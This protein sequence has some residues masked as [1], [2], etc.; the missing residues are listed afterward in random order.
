MRAFTHSQ[1][2]K[3]TPQAELGQ[4][5]I[6]CANAFMGEKQGQRHGRCRVLVWEPLGFN[7]ML[8]ARL[9]VSCKNRKPGECAWWKSNHES[10]SGFQP[11]KCLKRLTVIWEV[12]SVMRFENPIGGYDLELNSFL[13]P[14][15]KRKINNSL[16]SYCLCSKLRVKP[17]CV[18]IYWPLLT[19]EVGLLV[20]I[21]A[22]YSCSS[23]QRL[24]THNKETFWKEI[25]YWKN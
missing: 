25:I 7:G 20:G 23:R 4:M 17:I 19:L 15:S 12:E 13:Y 3:T 24:F 10:I 8:S 2:C 16:V 1:V 9:T 21:I 22:I 5:I 14:L 11:T 6:S 18:L